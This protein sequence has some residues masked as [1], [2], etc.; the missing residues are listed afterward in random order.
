MADTSVADVKI[1]YTLPEPT[2]CGAAGPGAATA[3]ASCVADVA[4]M[5]VST[6]GGAAEPEAAAVAFSSAADVAA[7]TEPANC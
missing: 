2:D 1:D 7:Q 4:A 3:A 5:T 6:R